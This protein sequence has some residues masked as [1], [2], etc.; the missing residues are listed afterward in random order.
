VD[1]ALVLPFVIMGLSHAPLMALL[2]LVTIANAWAG[3]RL[4]P[5][6]PIERFGE[7]DALLKIGFG[8]WM[9]LFFLAWGYPGLA[10]LQ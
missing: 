3:L 7:V 1:P 4:L 10:P 5:N 9:L 8:L 2:G 6:A